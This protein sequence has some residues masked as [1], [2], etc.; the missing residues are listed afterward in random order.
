MS[1][2]SASH[3]WNSPGMA[4]PD[5]LV[6]DF[7]N[8]QSAPTDAD[9]RP[10]DNRLL[11]H[12]LSKIVPA[13]TPKEH[14]Q[15]IRAMELL[16]TEGD[17]TAP[18]VDILT[19]GDQI[20]WDYDRYAAALDLGFEIRLVP[21][22]GDYA[23]ARLCVEA[24]HQQQLNGGLRA[25]T[26]VTSY[27]WVK[28]GRPVNI[29]PGVRFRAKPK[30]NQ[31]MADLAG[32]GTTL[33]SQAKE[34]CSLGL[35][36]LVLQRHITFKEAQCRVKLVRGADLEKPVKDGTMPFDQAHREALSLA[37]NGHPDEEPGPPTKKALT[38]HVQTLRK[39]VDGLEQ[40]NRALKESVRQ[41]TAEN[42]VMRDQLEESEKA[43]YKERAL[44]EAAEETLRQVKDKIRVEESRSTGALEQDVLSSPAI[45]MARVR[46]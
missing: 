41:L 29:P 39:N 8:P 2:S 33:I 35:S 14:R 34:I 19:L 4:E 24:L 32:V 26:V 20:L 13:R 11:Q 44:R 7:P 27:E 5:L 9:R 16:K 17:G 15:L 21:C 10:P 38:N 31:D 3:S 28:S 46:P 37:R 18:P 43:V 25:L 12:P 23:I 22:W 6:R 36:A 30:C 40:E 42:A 45:D 1:T